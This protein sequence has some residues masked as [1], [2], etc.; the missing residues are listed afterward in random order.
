[1]GKEQNERMKNDYRASISE[2]KK[3]ILNF[4]LGPYDGEEKFI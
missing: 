2:A 1:M 4:D 3:G